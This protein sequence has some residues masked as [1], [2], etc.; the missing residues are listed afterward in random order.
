MT[1]ATLDE[2]EDFRAAARSFLAGHFPAPGVCTTAKDRGVAWAQ[3][4][5]GLDL[6][7]LAIPS[8]YGGD[9]FGRAELL[10]ESPRV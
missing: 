3:M 10:I 1:V 9:G 5:K 2:R 4:A 8:E 7:G 6:P